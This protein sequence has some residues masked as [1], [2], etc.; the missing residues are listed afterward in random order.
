MFLLAAAL[1]VKRE[2]YLT[3]I[4]GILGDGD[5]GFGVKRGF[6]SVKAMLESR[7]W[8]E[9]KELLH[10]VSIELIKSMGGASGVIF[11]TM[12]FGGLEGIPEGGAVSVRDFGT[13]LLTG[14]RAVEKRGKASPGEKTMLDALHPA[15]MAYQNALRY[16]ED[17]EE[18]FRAAWEGAKRGVKDSEKLL[19]RTGRSKNFEDLAIGLP[20]P[21]AVSTSYIFEGFYLGVR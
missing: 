5:H 15:C 12:F 17:A 8:T 20:D 18:V 21:G 11:G 19:P 13:Y 14:E 9:A 6:L 10:A 7:E 3:E 16:S 1:I 2:P 4:D